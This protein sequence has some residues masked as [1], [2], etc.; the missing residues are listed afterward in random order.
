[1]TKFNAGDRVTCDIND[2]KA[3]VQ[4]GPVTSVTGQ[5]A[6]LVK[7]LEGA[8]EGSSGLVWSSDL[9]LLPKFEVGQKVRFNFSSAGKSYELVA[10]PFVGGDESFYVVRDSKGNH[11]TSFEKYMVP[12]VQ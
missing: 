7:W 12:V 2:L 1:M 10:G 6:Y 8:A 5:E 3:E 11:E 4:Y 9:T